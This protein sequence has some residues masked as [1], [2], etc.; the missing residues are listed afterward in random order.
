MGRQLPTHVTHL[1]EV[2]QSLRA[3][4]RGF[5]ECSQVMRLPKGELLGTSPGLWLCWRASIFGVAKKSCRRNR[6]RHKSLHNGGI[7]LIL[8]NINPQNSVPAEHK[9][10]L[11]DMGTALVSVHARGTAC[12]CVFT[13]KRCVFL[14]PLILVG[15]V[16][17]F[18]RENIMKMSLYEL[19]GQGLERP[20][21]S[22]LAFL[23]SQDHHTVK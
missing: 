23:D 15:P 20:G 5:L 19:Q 9:R 18:E 11:G 3:H 12:S 2:S 4:L 13:E 14:H 17:C 16:T 21:I 8:T 22:V 10:I 7:R 1:F 6:E